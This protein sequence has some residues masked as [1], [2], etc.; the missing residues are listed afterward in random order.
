MALQM[1][2]RSNME[3]NDN[4]IIE[5]LKG[6]IIYYQKLLEIE[7]SI[8]AELMDFKQKMVAHLEKLNKQP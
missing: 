7:K 4:E 5:Y 1:K 6:R 2:F 8:N 3:N